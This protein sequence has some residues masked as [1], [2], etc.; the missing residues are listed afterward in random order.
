LL[1]KNDATIAREPMHL[2]P[3]GGFY[4][5]HMKWDYDYSIGTL[6]P[7]VVVE[8]FR[9]TREEIQ[10]DIDPSYTHAIIDGQIMFLRGD[11]NHVLWDQVDK[12]RDANQ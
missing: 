5:G 1:G 4:P 7:D 10:R 6:K 8:L 9:P 12:V 3:K 11:S 2:D